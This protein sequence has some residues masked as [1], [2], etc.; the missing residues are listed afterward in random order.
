MP[1]LNYHRWNVSFL[2]I[3]KWAGLVML[4]NPVA[5]LDLPLKIIAWQDKENKVWYAFNESKYLGER[6]NLPQNLSGSL[7]IDAVS[8][9]AINS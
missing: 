2:V 5:A 9:K 6:Y 3:Q 1:G 8:A 4:E 7:D